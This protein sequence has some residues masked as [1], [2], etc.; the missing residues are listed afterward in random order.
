MRKKELWMMRGAFIL[1]DGKPG[2]I[3]AM[4]E[5]NLDGVD[6]VYYIDVVLEGERHSGRY[7]PD[8][9]TQMSKSANV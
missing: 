2:R 3:K 9:I 8:N 5:N 6:Y 1:A 4:Q 7:H